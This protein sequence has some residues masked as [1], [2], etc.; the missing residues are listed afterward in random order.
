MRPSNFR[1]RQSLTLSWSYIFHGENTI[2]NPFC[3]GSELKINFSWVL[4]LT[5]IKITKC[6]DIFSNS[7]IRNS[8]YSV[9][10]SKTKDGIPCRWNSVKNIIFRTAD[11][12]CNIFNVW[13]LSCKIKLCTFLPSLCKFPRKAIFIKTANA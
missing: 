9:H 1:R 6:R 2:N 7:G 5:D 10:G 4:L 11:F 3:A 12:L 13:K 8:A